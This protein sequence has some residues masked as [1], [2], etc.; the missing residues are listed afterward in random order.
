MAA[1]GFFVAALF[2]FKFWKRTKDALFANFGVAFVLFALS[3]VTSLAFDGPND[4][5]TWVY[6][7]RLVAFVMLLI[8]IVGKNLTAPKK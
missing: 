3:Q 4:D 1:A 6:L 8:A 2:F 5:K 7:L